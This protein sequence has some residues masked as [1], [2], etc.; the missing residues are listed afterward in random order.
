ML[1]IDERWRLISPSCERCRHLDR[2][3]EHACTAFPDGI[4]LEIW[5]GAHDHRSPYPGDHGMRF[6]AM[7]DAE[8][9][10]YMEE[11]DR[12]VAELE[13]R[14]EL[15]RAGLLAPVKPAKPRSAA[16]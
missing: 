7:S 11:V 6:Q 1:E 9:S 2:G 8:W 5:N 14:A 15:V 13:R 16:D 3:Q 10:R 4:P 12:H